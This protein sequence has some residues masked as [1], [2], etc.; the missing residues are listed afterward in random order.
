MVFQHGIPQEG[1]QVGS[2]VRI[3]RIE[4]KFLSK[5]IVHERTSVPS[6]IDT[7]FLR[8]APLSFAERASDVSVRL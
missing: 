4:K 1:G 2:M 5:L 6:G 3:D 7:M 8:D